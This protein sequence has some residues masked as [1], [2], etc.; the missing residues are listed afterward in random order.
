MSQRDVQ[1]LP[2]GPHTAEALCALGES[3]GL[4]CARVDLAGCMDK[5]ELLARIG[6]SMQFPDWFGGNWDALYDCLDDLSWLDARAHL[7]VIEHAGELRAAAQEDFVTL[8][9]VLEESAR[10][11][12]E[13]GVPFRAIVGAD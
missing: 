13:R 1:V 6:T 11:L 8:L 12:H 10:S 7:L 5:S 2:F 9:D 3:L 4:R